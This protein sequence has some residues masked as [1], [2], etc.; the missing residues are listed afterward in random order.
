MQIIAQCPWCSH[1]W[2]LAEDAADRRIT[3]PA[4]RQLFKIPPLHEV[5]RAAR[6]IKQARGTIYVDQ[7]GN[8]YG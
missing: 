2:L 5:P 7:H 4:C 3:C 1:C 8:T 6:I